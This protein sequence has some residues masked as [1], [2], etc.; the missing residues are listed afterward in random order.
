MNKSALY[1][2][3]ILGRVSTEDADRVLETIAALQPDVAGGPC[4][5]VVADRIKDAISDQIASD[6]PQVRLIPC[7]PDISLPEM[8]TRAYEASSGEIVAVTEDHCVPSPGWVGKIQRAF[9]N[10][11]PS[12]SAVGG[13]VVN[14]V[15]DTGLDWATFLCEYSFFSPP[16]VEGRTDILPGMNIAYRRSVLDAA[17]RQRLSEGFWETT[18]HSHLLANG[19]KFRSLNEL[20]MFHKKRFSWRLFASQRFV[21]SRY[22]AGC[23]LRYATRTK[24]VMMAGAS[25]LLPPILLWRMVTSARRKGLNRELRSAFPW[26]AMLVVI[27]AAGESVGA[28]LGPGDALARIE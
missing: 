23:R 3:V 26:L 5:I 25:L 8:R 18:L 7:D 9:A 20:I 22:Y 15:T 4:E 17:P 19:G 24:R 14:G 16:V 12:L 10:A 28:L 11:P 21:Y 13:S 2:S 1:T 27:W 6:Y